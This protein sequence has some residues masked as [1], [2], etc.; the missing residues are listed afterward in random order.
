MET[1]HYFADKKIA[2][3]ALPLMDNDL[4]NSVVE[5]H[6]RILMNELLEKSKASKGTFEFFVITPTERE[7][8]LCA[9]YFQRADGQHILRGVPISREKIM[10]MA[11][12][13]PYQF[14]LDLYIPI[15]SECEK[16]HD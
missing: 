7:L 14:H 13:K 3:E 11:N 2:V 6:K 8:Q 10:E 16:W 4:I 15:E 12:G 1:L 5:T 9:D